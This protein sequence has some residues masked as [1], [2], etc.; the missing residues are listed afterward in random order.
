M[1]LYLVLLLYCTFATSLRLASRYVKMATDYPNLEKCLKKE[2]AS[3]FKPMEKSFYDDNVKF[4]DPL[5]T[6]SGIQNYINNVDML[7]GRTTLGSILFDDAS[8][9]LHNIIQ[10]EKNKIQT[11]WT[12][13]VTAKIVPGKP[14]AKFTGVSIYTLD[15]E[16][17]ILQQD[18]YWDSINLDRGRYI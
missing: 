13:Q 6:F 15:T 12:L 16:G 8:I 14:R 10:L 4:I 7:A 1:K 18:D 11:R 17:K 2:Y 9:S 5:N 3:F